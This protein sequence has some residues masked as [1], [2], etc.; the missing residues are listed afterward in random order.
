[1][2][3]LQRCPVPASMSHPW[4]P[5]KQPHALRSWLV[6]F[7]ASMYQFPV[8]WLLSLLKFGGVKV[9]L[10]E[11]M[12]TINATCRK[13]MQPREKG[14][15]SVNLIKLMMD[16]KDPD[17]GVRLTDKQILDNARVFLIAGSGLTC[18]TPPQL[19]C[20]PRSPFWGCGASTA[21]NCKRPLEPT[22]CERAN[23]TPTRWG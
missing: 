10:V 4:S 9:R 17:T 19:V 11:A 20:H 5:N 2:L 6:R 3:L 21:I 23:G 1:M 18:R 15:E 7:M 13:S 14:D 16:A 8:I 22:Q 12:D